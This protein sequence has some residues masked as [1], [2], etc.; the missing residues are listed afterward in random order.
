MQPPYPNYITYIDYYW[1]HVGYFQRAIVRCYQIS[2]K[3]Y[4]R[5]FKRNTGPLD[6]VAHATQT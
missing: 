1:A 6:W 5:K 2:S 3:E 4:F